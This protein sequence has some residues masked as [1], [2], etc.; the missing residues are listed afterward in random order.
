MKFQ[1]P[2]HNEGMRKTWPLLFASLAMGLV[3]AGCSGGA[4]PKSPATATKEA[5]GLHEI[6]VGDATTRPLVINSSAWTTDWTFSCPAKSVFTFHAQGTGT[7]TGMVEKGASAIARTGT[8]VVH[9]TGP[10]SFLIVVQ[11]GGDCKWTL[12]VTQK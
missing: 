2:G 11:A 10:G 1:D 5:P 12:V 6:G 8:G 3:A 7:T 9:F 4:P